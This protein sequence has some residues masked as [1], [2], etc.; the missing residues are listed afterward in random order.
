MDGAGLG[1]LRCVALLPRWTA[2]DV[3]QFGLDTGWLEW[4]DAVE[5]GP[6]VMR[7][8]HRGKAARFDEPIVNYRGFMVGRDLVFDNLSVLVLVI[9]LGRSLCL[10]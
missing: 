8:M 9:E 3:D 7:S 1:R 4:A 6:C 5:C 2:F 10:G